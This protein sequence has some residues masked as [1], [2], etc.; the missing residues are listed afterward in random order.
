M[1]QAA[2]TLG[3]YGLILIAFV[4]LIVVNIKVWKKDH[5]KEKQISVLQ[6]QL[7]YQ[8]EEN[9]KIQSVNEDLKLKINSL[10]KG[11]NEMLEEKAREDFGMVR[12]NETFFY[13][14][15]DKDKK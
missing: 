13:Y 5:D 10:T 2:K 8:L 6:Q 7:A 12:D 9:S 4:L 14:N 3:K 11:S 15:E 1:Q